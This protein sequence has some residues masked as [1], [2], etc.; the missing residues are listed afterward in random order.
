MILNNTLK[1]YIDRISNDCILS[2]N[3][4]VKVYNFFVI[5][6]YKIVD[7]V[8]FW[9]II[10]LDLCWVNSDFLDKTNKKI[11]S[12]ISLWKEIILF[13]CIS[14]IFKEKYWDEIIYIDSKSHKDIEK[15]FE[16]KIWISK[17]DALNYKDKITILETDN[18][19]K[20]YSTTLGDFDKIAFISISDWCSLNC[21]YCN[22]KKIKWNTIS[23]SLDDILEQIKIELKKWKNNIYLLSDDCWS[24]WIDIWSNFVDLLDKIFD[25][26]DSI[27]VNITNIYPL[28]LLKFYDR[29]KKYIFSNKITSIVI[30]IQHTSR[31]ILSLMN[32]RYD[33]DKIIDVL[34]EI[35]KESNVQLQNHII[36]D[37]HE[38]TIEEFVDTFKLLKF[39]DKNFYF[40][41]SDVN[42]IYWK[43][44]TSE[45]LKQKI[46]LLKKL[47][48]KYNIDITL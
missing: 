46:I 32:R 2:D 16:F 27:N 28:F 23:S 41:Y 8:S 43:T 42:N 24:Y 10:I 9:D 22:I 3:K 5:N 36:F 18:S 26:D 40:R 21:S 30:P 20:N 7:D 35:K 15:Y 11:E 6:N 17:I 38:E 12:Y 48:N 33:I 19:F 13:G 34:D 47:Q 29:M 39:Y 45:I 1:I 25:I 31:R 4:F 14:N 37:Y 44:L